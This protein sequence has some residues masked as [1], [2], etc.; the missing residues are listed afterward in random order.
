MD[1]PLIGPVL[2]PGAQTTGCIASSSIVRVMLVG[3]VMTTAPAVSTAGLCRLVW[4]EQVTSATR[5]S[6]VV[7][8]RDRESE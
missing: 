5:R 3:S 6:P 4:N 1:S 8:A 2:L 7:V